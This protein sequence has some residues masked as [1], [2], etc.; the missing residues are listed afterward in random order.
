MSGVLVDSCLGL[1]KTLIEVDFLGNIWVP[2]TMEINSEP[3][4]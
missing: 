3:V 1:P 2:I 4:L